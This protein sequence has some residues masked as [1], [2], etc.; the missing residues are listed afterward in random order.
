M[1][2]WVM[3]QRNRG[4]APAQGGRGQGRGSRG[5]GNAGRGGPQAHVSVVRFQDIEETCSN[6]TMD[7]SPNAPNVGGNNLMASSRSGEHGG[8]AGAGFGR[9]RYSMG[10]RT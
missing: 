7:G 8:R 4:R 9:G 1:A 6:L 3:E 10:G 5:R 2:N